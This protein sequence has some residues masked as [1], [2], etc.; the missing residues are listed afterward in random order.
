[1]IWSV[2]DD[3]VSLL[4]ARAIL[5]TEGKGNIIRLQKVR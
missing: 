4:H 3:P 2:E 1:M 5:R